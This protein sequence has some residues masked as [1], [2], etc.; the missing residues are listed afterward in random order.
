[1]VLR[2][3]DIKANLFAGGARPN[4]YEVMFGFPPGV[5][6]PVRE[7]SILCKAASLPSSTLGVIDIPYKGRIIH[8]AGDREYE[9]WSATIIN[10]G[11]M[12]I[13]SAFEQWMSIINDN[14]SNLAATTNPSDYQVDMS[15]KQLSKDN[16]TLKEYYLKDVW[17]TNIGAIDLSYD[18]SNEIEEFTV[19]FQMN[20][21]SE[22]ETSVNI[23]AVT[24]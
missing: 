5:S 22:R 17:P 3:N 7:S 16:A 2:I 8:I 10:D 18:S 20:Y 12:N 19:E 11:E 4:L 21:W 9:P 14:D 15:V 1:M 13:R 23:A 6:S 24:P